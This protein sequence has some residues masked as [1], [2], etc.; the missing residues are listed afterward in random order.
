M[1][2]K[3]LSKDEYYALLELFGAVNAFNNCASNLE[4]RCKGI[5]AGQA[6][7]LL[8]ISTAERLMENLLATIPVRKLQAIK[9]DLHFSRCELKITPDYTGESKK[10]G[11]AYVPDK[12]LSNVVERLVNWECM[13][14][15][16]SK[17]KS[18]QCKILKEIAAL[19]PWELP[20]KNDGCPL[21][22]LMSIMED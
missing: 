5:P 18:K 11:Y 8:L 4:R 9:K 2:R 15:D 10:D 20:S 3:P 19:Y 21:Q 13:L 12:A 1:E 7:M 16:K 17:A 14:C 6:D 22:G